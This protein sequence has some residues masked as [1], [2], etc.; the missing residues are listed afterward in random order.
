MYLFNIEIKHLLD[1]YQYFVSNIIILIDI[2]WCKL[3]SLIIKQFRYFLEWL[4]LHPMFVKPLMTK[5]VS[6][7]YLLFHNLPDG[8]IQSLQILNVIVQC[9]FFSIYFNKY[10]LYL[11]VKMFWCFTFSKVCIFWLKPINPYVAFGCN[12]KS[13]VAPIYRLLS[14]LMIILTHIQR[15]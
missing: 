15:S 1:W 5:C 14:Y 3:L 12:K 8:G 10:D 6:F 7:I 13:D 11:F 2:Y 4:L 9:C